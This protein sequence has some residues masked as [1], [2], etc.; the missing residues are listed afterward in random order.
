MEGILSSKKKVSRR[1]KEVLLLIYRGKSYKM[2]AEEMGITIETV[3]TYIKRVYQKLEVHSAL[4]A[5]NKCSELGFL[6]H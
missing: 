3:R 5:L 2:V 4:E 6:E 1:E